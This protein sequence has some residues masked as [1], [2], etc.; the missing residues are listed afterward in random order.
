MVDIFNVKCTTKEKRTVKLPSFLCTSNMLY[1]IKH[2]TLTNENRLHYDKGSFLKMHDP[3][4][5]QRI[6]NFC[7]VYEYPLNIWGTAKKD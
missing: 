4:K 6:F 7:F 2:G 1:G 3:E 5:E